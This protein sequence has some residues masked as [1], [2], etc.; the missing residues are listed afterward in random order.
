MDFFR[1]GL[2][3]AERKQFLAKILGFLDTSLELHHENRLDSRVVPGAHQGR[4]IN[5]WMRVEHTF[6]WNRV[7]GFVNR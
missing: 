3:G 1:K 2:S 7:I 4:A 5:L 6:A